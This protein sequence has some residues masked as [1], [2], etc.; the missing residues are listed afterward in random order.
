VSAEA[1][2]ETF[3]DGVEPAGSWVLSLGRQQ[4][5]VGTQLGDDTISLVVK[6][7]EEVPA[8]HLSA[9]RPRLLTPAFALQLAARP[10]WCYYK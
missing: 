6:L 2:E 5:P 8:P 9:W 10:R 7:A 3:L 1:S 4:V